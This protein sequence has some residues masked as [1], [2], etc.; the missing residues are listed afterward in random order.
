[1][2]RSRQLGQLRLRR[3]SRR[4]ELMLLLLSSL[5]LLLLLLLLLRCPRRLSLLS[6]RRQLIRRRRRRRDGD[7]ASAVA[8]SARHARQALAP[9]AELAHLA[10]DVIGK[11]RVL[12]REELQRGR[13]V[14]PRPELGRQVLWGDERRQRRVDVWQPVWCEKG[15][16]LARWR[17][18]RARCD[19]VGRLRRA[20]LLL[21]LLGRL[22]LLLRL[23]RRLRAERRLLL[24]LLR[25]LM[26]VVRQLRGV[27]GRRRLRH[28]AHRLLLLML[29]A[30]GVKLLLE[31]LV[32]SLEGSLRSQASSRVGQL[33]PESLL[34]RA[35]RT[36][37]GHHLLLPRK[38]L[39]RHRRRDVLLLLLRLLLAVEV[40]AD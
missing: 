12:L 16:R 38:R 23:L 13:V 15:H 17:P 9:S 20:V 21:L 35:A 31:L 2:A 24:L 19:G 39:G 6:L 5:K 14:G 10:R 32:A 8:N 22:L 18:A 37:D 30:V 36:T 3:L 7:G 34:K 33:S 40:A 1:L 29:V 25:L 4:L 11:G 26:L 28:L 27:E